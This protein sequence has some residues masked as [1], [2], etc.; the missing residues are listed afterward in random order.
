MMTKHEAV[1][2]ILEGRGADRIPVIMNA[3]SLPPAQYGYTMPEVLT[4]PKKMVECMVGTRDRVGYD[5]LMI[6]IYSLSGDVGG[7][8]IDSEGNPAITGE[9]VIKSLEELPKLK[10][11]KVQESFMMQQLLTAIKMAKEVAPEEPLFVIVNHP[12][13]EAFKLIGATPAFKSMVKHPE[14]IKGVAEYIEDWVFEAHKT[15]AEA[16]VDFLWYPTPNFG[17]FCISKKTYEK[18]IAES[19]IRFINR[20]KAIGAPV[21]LHTCG[22]Y[23]DRFDLVLKE[24]GD[25]WHLADTST[26]KV[27]DEYGDK[28]SLMGC[29]PSVSVMLEGT[30]QEVYDFAFKECMDGAKDG[31][32]ILSADCDVPPATPDANMKAAVRAARDAEK[33]LF[34]S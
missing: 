29:I 15:I 3:C 10:P 6:G 22:L 32:F 14:L 11:F 27:K 5:G 30:E 13:S 33:I 28:V 34:H 26:K 24:N 7:H 17:G 1:K 20:M 9:D 23:D 8:L 12:T 18:C 4:D 19:N 16:G 2:A 25:C 21:V 31:R